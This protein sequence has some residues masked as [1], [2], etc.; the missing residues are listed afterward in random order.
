MGVVVGDSGSI[1]WEEGRG[2]VEIR[3][4]AGFPACRQVVELGMAESDRGEL[5]LHDGVVGVDVLSGLWLRLR[6]RSGAFVGEQ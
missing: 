3:R 6:L 4:V 2:G 1:S 5:R